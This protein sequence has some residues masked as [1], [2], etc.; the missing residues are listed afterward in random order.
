P[1]PNLDRLAGRGVRFTNWY[2]A[3][4]VCSPSRAALLTG[5]YPQRTGVSRI[6]GAGRNS[7][8]LYE[9]EVTIARALKKLRY[10]TGLFGKWH[11]G[12]SAESRPG[13]Q[14]FDDWYGFLAG[15]ID[16]YSHIM[17]WEM[18][19]GIY[20]VHDLWKN[21]VEVWENGT[22]FTDIITRESRRFIRENS[23]WPF[24]LY[25]AYNAPHYPMHAPQKYFDR[26][27][28]LDPHRRNQAAMVASVDDSIGEIMAELTGQGL[29]EDTVI[30]FQSDNGATIEKRCLLDNSGEFYHGGSNDEFRGWKGG[31]CEGGI[32]MP[33]IL[34]WP[35]H[36]PEGAVC[37][38][39][40]CAI[41]ILPTFLGIAGA[42][43]P[44]GKIIDGRDILP[45]A[46]G[47]VKSPHE[48]IFWQ[49]GDQLAV[50]E[51][52][53]KLILQGKESFEDEPV[54]PTVFLANLRD[55]PDESEN[56]AQRHAGVADRLTGLCR[57]WKEDM[58]TRR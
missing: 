29:L 40:G 46:R 4:P 51:G 55:D 52:D 13:S 24:L 17:Y 34:S 56:L 25:V 49:Y 44:A 9:D 39:L 7:P 10:R 31:L 19:A 14:G 27:K 43:L 50:H 18:G 42:A 45:M 12:S 58:E 37:T 54:L 41:D 53:W 1:T 38:E 28:H 36:L 3:S 33:A 26:F 32:R 23:R 57:Q 35:G 15:C 8:G 30:F 5:R 6:L 47:E 48:R 11:L 2:S 16:Y 21:D 20:P 22:Y